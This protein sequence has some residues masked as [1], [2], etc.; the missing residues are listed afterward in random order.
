MT[1]V[2]TLS[3]VGL[4]GQ[5]PLAMRVVGLVEGAGSFI[6]NNLLMCRF[7]GLVRE[8]V[9]GLVEGGGHG[10]HPL[11]LRTRMGRP[12]QSWGGWLD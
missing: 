6:I 4:V 1:M 3:F 12:P 10:H 5:T 8:N 11:L 7:G 9:E 2:I